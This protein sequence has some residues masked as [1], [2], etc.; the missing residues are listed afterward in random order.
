[1]TY[2][3][4]PRASGE[5]I[6]L[7]NAKTIALD[8]LF[9]SGVF[10]NLRGKAALTPCESLPPGWRPSTDSRPTV[11]ECAQHVA[12]AL[13]AE[14]GRADAAAAL[15]AEM[16]AKEADARALVHRLF[17]IATD[18]GWAQEALV[19]NELAQ[20]W[21]R[22]EERAGVLSTAVASGIAAAVQGELALG[23]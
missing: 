14:D 21:P 18:K 8:T 19:W 12:R 3:Y 10:T 5:L 11:W 7:A 23:A 22:L 2:G 4:D 9:A 1:M 20:E 15:I 16:G 17:Q 6:T 13:I